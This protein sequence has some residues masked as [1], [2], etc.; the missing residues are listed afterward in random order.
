M[1]RGGWRP[2]GEVIFEGGGNHAG[3]LER[4]CGY[5]QGAGKRKALKRKQGRVFRDGKEV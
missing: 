1:E 4:H 3:Y 2:H 5:P